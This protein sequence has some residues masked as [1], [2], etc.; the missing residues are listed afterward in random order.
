MSRALILGGGA[1]LRRC[2]AETLAEAGYAVFATARRY[3]ADTAALTCRA[4]ARP[5]AREAARFAL[6][7]MVVVLLFSVLQP[8]GE[9]QFL[10]SP[11]P[12]LF[13]HVVCHLSVYRNKRGLESAEGTIFK[14]LEGFLPSGL[15]FPSCRF[16]S[17]HLR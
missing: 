15:G 11:P 3:R 6:C 12:L 4:R 5:R 8:G 14:T 1:P 10:P 7:F 9:W 17:P 2:L 16:S 13:R